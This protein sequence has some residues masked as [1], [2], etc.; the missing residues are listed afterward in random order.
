MYVFLH[1]PPFAIGIKSLDASQLRQSQALLRVLNNHGQVRHMF[2]GHVHRAIAG[3]WCGIPTT[4]LPG[5]NH[6][7]ALYLGEDSTMIGSHEASAYGVCLIDDMC[8]NVHFQ[9]PLDH[10]A[11]FVLSDARSKRAK[12]PGE[13]V[14]PPPCVSAAL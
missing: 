2:Y 3:S 1:H 6:Q 8:V 5:T 14:A 12:S 4:T 7:V 11:R 10:S 13:L 9:D